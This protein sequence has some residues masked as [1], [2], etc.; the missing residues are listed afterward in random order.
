MKAAEKGKMAETLA[1]A[2]FMLK[3]YRIIASN[4]VTGRGTSAG[5]VDFIALKDNLLVFVEVKQRRTLEEAAYAILPE[6]QQRIWYG[7]ESF[8]QK[9]Q[10]Y[11]NVNIRFD[12]VLVSLPFQIRHIE[13]AW[14]L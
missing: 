5:E 13:D 3:G 9:N 6:Q 10:Q 8:L 7:A 4:F 2:M 14:R 11:Q 1:K 12:A